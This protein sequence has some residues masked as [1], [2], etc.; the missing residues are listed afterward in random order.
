MSIEIIDLTNTPDTPPSKPIS[1]SNA[2]M[3]LNFGPVSVNPNLHQHIHHHQHQTTLLVP[4][5]P[6]HTNETP[7]IAT[8]WPQPGVFHSRVTTV[9]KPLPEPNTSQLS[10]EIRL[11][12][13]WSQLEHDLFLMGLIEYGKGR[14]SKI[15]KHFVCSKTPQQVQNYAASFFKHLPPAYVHGF[16]RRKQISNP[17]NSFSKRNRNSSNYSMP[18]MIPT[19]QALTLLPATAPYHQVGKYYGGEASTS[20]MN[21]GA[22]TSMTIMPNATSTNGKVDLELR[23]AL[24]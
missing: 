3:I 15:A 9:L 12:V 6:T 4:V 8:G 2:S 16:K 11:G 14:W 22:S 24:C 5:A 23:L 17:N 19:K 10:S 7:Q 1:S 13:R 20:M 21:D 18:N